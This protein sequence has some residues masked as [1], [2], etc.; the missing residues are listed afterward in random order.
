M[1]SILALALCSVGAAVALAKPPV[2][3]T[4][5]V[6]PITSPSGPPSKLVLTPPEWNFGKVISGAPAA[7]EVTIANQGEGPLK[8]SIRSSCGCTA[9]ANLE[10]ATRLT[11]Q[12]F[13]YELGPGKSDKLKINYNTK[14]LVKD[15]SQTIT[16]TSNDPAQPMYQ[17]KVTGVVQRMFEMFEDE[18]STERVVFGGLERDSA[19][20]RVI[21]LRNTFDEPVKLSLADGGDTAPFKVNLE[22]LTP[23]K[24]YKLHV[25]TVPPLKNGANTLEIKLATDNKEISEIVVPVTAFIQPRVA[26]TR[27]TLMVAPNTTAPIRQR[28]QIRYQQSNPIQ[29][30][31]FEYSQPGIKAELLPARPVRNPAAATSWAFHD[32]EV[33]IPPAAEL[34]AEGALLTIITND[35]DPEYARFE[36][37]IQVLNRAAN[38]VVPAQPG[39][40]NEDE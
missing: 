31:G 16:I 13:Q 34:P 11:G 37:R 8:F 7:T 21:D 24:E 29:V 20:T 25:S 30:S 1:K 2:P 5:S 19:Q 40:K 18:K 6:V 38:R 39:Q 28:V 26:L 22:V 3:V 35:L 15:V 14:K 12:D 4:P 33:T 32:I 17:F 27:S 10:T 36:V 9:V 23:G